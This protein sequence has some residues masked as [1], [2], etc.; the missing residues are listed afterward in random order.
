[1][2][3][4]LMSLLKSPTPSWCRLGSSDTQSRTGWD[5]LRASV[6]FGLGGLHSRERKGW[7]AMIHDLNGTPV[8]A[9]SMVGFWLLLVP[10]IGSEVHAWLV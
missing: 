4:G 10:L 7:L 3:F 1:M 6:P 5:T 9:A 8:A 2:S